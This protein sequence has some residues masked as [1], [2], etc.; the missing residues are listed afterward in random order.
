MITECYV[1]AWQIFSTLLLTFAIHILRS[2]PGLR[3]RS[4]RFSDFLSDSE[5]GSPI[6]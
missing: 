5:T 6:D 2:S 1:K 4:R 3:S